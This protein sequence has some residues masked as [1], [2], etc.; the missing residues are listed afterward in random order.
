MIK[1]H[2]KMVCSAVLSA[3]LIASAASAL[4]F[5]AEKGTL[6]ANAEVYYIY[7]DYEYQINSDDTLTITSYTGSG[8]YV[9][10]PSTIK[11]KTV[12]VIG[13]YAFNTCTGIS[14]LTLPGTIKKIERYAFFNCSNIFSLTIPNSVTEIEEG[15]FCGCA[16]LTSFTFPSSI[17]EIPYA[18][19]KNCTGFK[20][21]TI[22]ST[23]KKINS[24]AFEGCTFL[25]SVTIPDTITE[26]PNFAFMNCTG[27]NSLTIPESVTA[28]GFNAFEG[29]GLTSMEIPYSVKKIGEC[30]FLDC[31]QMTKIFIPH[32]V[33]D[34]GTGAFRNCKKL[35]IYAK[36]DSFAE[37]YADG[38]NIAFNE[39]T[40]DL[41]KST[42]SS[43]SIF[44]GGS[45]TLTAV[46]ENGKG[47]Y[48]YAFSV[49]NPEGK[50]F[51]IKSYSDANTCKF[52][53][54]LGG[55]YTLRIQAKDIKGVTGKKDLDLTVKP[56]FTNVSTISET[57]ITRGKSVT[58]NAAVSGGSGTYKY[59]YVTLAP[60]GKWYVLKDYG[61]ETS[62]RFTPRSVGT[63][64]I[65]VKAKDAK[66]IIEF[67]EFE[68]TVLKEITNNSTISAEK[69]AQGV[70]VTITGSASDGAAPYQFAYVAQ[71]P[72]GK[73]YVLKNYSS[74]TSCKF[75]PRSV[76]KYT[77]QVKAKDAGDTIRIKSFTLDVTEALKNDSAISAEKITK[78]QSITITGAAS[79]GTPSYQYAYVVQ[80]PKGNWCVLK[81][82]SEATS[83]KWTPGSVGKY[84]VQ[85]KVKDNSGIIKIKAFTL[86]VE[87]ALTNNSTIS[88]ESI[89]K[90]Q[91]VTFSGAASYG[92]PSYQYAYVV[93][94]P[95]GNWCVL[96][97]YSEAAS[98]K[99][100]PASAG[101]YTV[102]V[103]VKDSKD[104][105][106]IKSFTLKV[107]D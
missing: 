58:I 10:V 95:K 41:S 77:V 48:Q 71:A 15:A 11:G 23:I 105:I 7:G 43:G 70:G 2:L 86:E 74:E 55:N 69:I 38:Y 20:K 94:T 35:T 57:N 8:S 79:H 18:A 17:T 89:K 80:T 66:G 14:R 27:L 81:N 56:T 13:E 91:T 93:K 1:K 78:G 28:I 83:L 63:Y 98:H 88:A 84:T 33:T 51:E 106:S 101:T 4:P 62:C 29:C 102:Q 25:T 9:S 12:T 67:K 54:A 107:S 31:T 49:K 44:R 6:T 32:T 50:W 34:I 103:K 61:S 19:F 82:Y 5:A 92:T 46:A 72:D 16:S 90:G 3:L 73:W 97:N 21:F 40:L 37:L 59:A 36:K 99:W 87:N 76:G 42:V 68:L 104:A 26:I 53:P 64:K 100:K 39:F 52:A 45:V 65:Q 47:E 24:R 85:V 30:A 22:Q 96:K 75:Y 60:D